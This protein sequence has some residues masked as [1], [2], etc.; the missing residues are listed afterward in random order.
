MYSKN[1]HIHFMG[2]GGIGMSGIAKILKQK[3]YIVSGCD[4]HKDQKNITDLIDTNCSVYKNE[5]NASCQA[6]NISILVYSTAISMDHPEITNSQKNG[7]PVIHRSVMLAELIRTQFSIA[8]TGSHGKTTTSSI[9]SDLLIKANLDPTII[10]GGNL[11]SIT[12]NA[13]YGKGK[14]TVIEA[15]ESD[16]SLLNLSPTFGIITNI[17]LEHLETYK[18][19]HDVAATFNQFLEQ[20][21]FYGK[22]FICI[23]GKTTQSLLPLKKTTYTTYGLTENA[24][25]SARNIIHSPDSSTYN[26]YYKNKNMGTITIAM[27][28]IHN[29]LNSLVAVAIGHE[30]N[31][32]QK[33]ISEALNSFTGVDRRFT[34][35][36]LYKDASVFDDYGHHPEEIKHS[37]ESAQRKTKN[38]LT[39]LF[40][41]HRYTRTE[42]LWDEFV[43]LFSTAPID[44]LIITD[45]FEASE[46]PIDKI[47]SKH[48]VDVIK[49]INPRLNISYIPFKS[50]Y[51]ELKNTID[52][53]LY[54]GDTLLLQGAGKV[55]KIADHLI[56][57]QA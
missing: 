15:D 2:I 44:N 13:H 1:T 27:P 31:I 5:K 10:I 37:I 6:K 11:N 56:E 53:V 22:A 55:N 40:Q 38:K 52:A 21:P 42:R 48:L 46:T 34:F 25:W 7:I 20:I 47:T 36:G 28:G 39:M 18:N 19:L 17:N 8:I 43:S 45:I 51:N 50:D 12:S 41:P 24:D 33:T 16:R 3:G 30:I 29:V 9:I 23:E 14:Y 26:A 4:S 32:S 35:K 54:K 57:K 49:K